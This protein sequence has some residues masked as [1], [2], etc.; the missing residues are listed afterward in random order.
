MEAEKKYPVSIIKAIHEVKSKVQYV[1]KDGKNEFH[2]YKYASEGALIAALHPA[3]QAAGLVIIPSGE[4]LILPDA[5]GNT[6][7]VMTYTLTHISGD[8]WP[9]KIRTYG[10]GGDKAKNGN[11]GDKGTYKALTGVNKY[12]LRQLFQIETGTDPEK[13]GGKGDD[14]GKPPGNQTGNQGAKNESADQVKNS[15][16]KMGKRVTEAQAVRFHSIKKD[17]EWSD[18]AARSLLAKYGYEST[19]DMEAWEDYDAII[20]E[21]QKGM[22]GKAKADAKGYCIFANGKPKEPNG[23]QK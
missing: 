2:G 6:H 12:F 9:D 1:Q 10:A 16:G 18:G 15:K 13:D 8:V 5:H 21:L 22:D 23:G 20:K 11:I 7:V 17:F 14:N 3:I 4:E 19:K